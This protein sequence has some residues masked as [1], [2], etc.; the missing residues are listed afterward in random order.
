M[1]SNDTGIVAKGASVTNQ[2]KLVP[3]K[4]W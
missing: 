2:Y 1:R 3:V 4:G